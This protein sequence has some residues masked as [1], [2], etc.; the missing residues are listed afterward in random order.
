MRFEIKLL[1]K[2]I[3]VAALLGVA[4]IGL[5]YAQSVPS[6]VI[7]YGGSSAVTGSGSCTG[8]FCTATAPLAPNLGGTG[9]NNSGATGFPL[10][11]AGVQSIISSTGTGVVVRA[12]SPSIATGLTLSF[13]TGSGARC[14]HVDNAGAVT[15]ATADCGTGT[16]GG[17]TTQ[18]QYN[19]AGAFGGIT[20]ATTNGTTLTLASP[21]L[22]GTVTGAGTVPN[23]VLVN[24]AVT[25]CGTSTSL[26]GSLTATA[27]LDSLGSTQ[28]Q[29]LYRNATNWTILAPGS[30]GQLL[31]SGGAAANPS[32]ITASGTGTVTT[33]TSAP[34][35]LFS[36]GATCTTTCT[37]STS[38]FQDARTTT[39]EVVNASDGGK[40][41]SASNAS[42]SAYSIVQANTAGFLAGFGTDLHNIN[43]GVV[44]LTAATSVFDNGLTTLSLARGQDASIWSDSVN[45]HSIVSVPVMATNTLLGNSSGTTNYPTAQTVGTGVLT[46][47]SNALSGAG[48]VTSTIASGTSA[49]GTAAIS[50]ATCATV[51]TTSAT[52]TATTDTV[53]ASFNG[54]PTAVTG[55]APATTGMLTIIGY[56]TA[57]NVNFKVCNNTSASITP[58]A[59]TL[60]WRILR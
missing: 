37:V 29:I 21:A 41:I 18:V 19:N 57:N 49:M 56:P 35:I 22:T 39:T 27:C 30:S 4:Y 1:L 28:G 38:V 15:I 48:G 34:G 10:W 16:P 40:I 2:K 45:Y 31:Q 43:A 44:T 6:S 55:Y 36:S 60:N 14:L 46:A 7:S 42:A 13:A 25:L 32:W 52:N 23:A 26:G 17:S 3:Y 33:L 54:D 20:G 5:A 24:S 59:I 11:T 12:T 50:S 8:A 51:V 47:M 9:L 53:L 58:G